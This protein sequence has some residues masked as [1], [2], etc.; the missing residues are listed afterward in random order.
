MR[1]AFVYVVRVISVAFH[2][3]RHSKI[4]P[5]SNARIVTDEGRL[6]AIYL[7]MKKGAT[8]KNDVTP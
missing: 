2:E 4:F 5:L 1:T 8:S 6:L 3:S 7:Q